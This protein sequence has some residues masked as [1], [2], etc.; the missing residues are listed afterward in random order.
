MGINV[1]IITTDEEI[2]EMRSSLKARCIALED[3]IDAYIKTLDNLST[4]GFIS[5]ETSKA[6][7]AFCEVAKELKDQYETLGYSID[8]TMENYKE[9]IDESDEYL[10]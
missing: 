5:G 7:K 1:N 9:G 8:V 6:I 10:Y 2:D 3:K 4:V